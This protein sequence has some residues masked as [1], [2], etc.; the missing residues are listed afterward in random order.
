MMLA[1]HGQKSA[2]KHG[3]ALAPSCVQTC[4]TQCMAVT[5]TA[6]VQVQI[7][8]AGNV[9]EQGYR[10][11]AQDQTKQR[12]FTGQGADSDIVVASTRAYV[13][14]LN[15]MMAHLAAAAPD[16]PAAATVDEAGSPAAV[17]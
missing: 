7:R 14:A 3:H 4:A 6:A 16:P 17:A 8:P 2:E 13:A 5:V 15:K 9:A 10:T 11:N 1:K 12:L